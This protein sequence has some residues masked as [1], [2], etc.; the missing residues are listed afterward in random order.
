MRRDACAVVVIATFLACAPSES[1]WEPCAYLTAD[2]L[3][4]VSGIVRSRR[5]PGVFWVH[6]DSGDA[7]RIF[8]I[9][10]HGT[11]LAEVWVQGADNEDWEDITADDHGN[12]YL[13][14]TGNNNNERT[15]LVVYV[16][17]EPD[18]TR[19]NVVRVDSVHVTRR[20]PFYY[21]EQRA[22][23]DPSDKNY[24]CEAVFWDAGTLYLLTKHRSDRRTVLYRLPLDGGVEGM[25]GDE[26]RPAQRVSAMDF[27]SQ[28]TAADLSP[29]GRLLAVL[30]YEYLAIFERPQTGDDFL[31]GKQHRVL[32]EGRQCEAITF[33]G[34]RLVFANEQRELYCL[35][36]SELLKRDTFLPRTPQ[37]DVPRLRDA[38]TTAA[39]GRVVPLVPGAETAR[40]PRIAGEPP[41]L[42]LAWSAG[43]LH[44]SAVWDDLEPPRGESQSLMLLMAGPPGEEPR[45]VPGQVVW[46][47]RETRAGVEL[48]RTRPRPRSEWVTVASTRR[49]KRLEFHARIDVPTG[50][51]AQL[52]F[53]AVVRHPR[54]GSEWCWSASSSAQ[55]DRNGVLW[56][57]LRLQP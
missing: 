43:G 49:A 36:L 28:V 1:P 18:V 6:N 3:E 48:R 51:E 13:S 53:N 26:R 37:L 16:V 31:A 56:G 33:D 10:A 39:E 40:A 47:V 46:Q 2:A 15:N 8:A 27:G 29:D 11:M 14:D 24:D 22:F 45:L 52:A 9:D 32:I 12:L 42:R 44:V 41:Q 23:P 20:I 54:A 50:A 34:S 57:R 25:H 21:P 19:R 4:E 38:Q 7:P 30:S 55:P 17:P 35:P 5:A